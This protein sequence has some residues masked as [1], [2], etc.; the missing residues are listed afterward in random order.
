[1]K[2]MLLAAGRGERLRPLTDT[3]PKPL[4]SVGGETLIE[5][6]VNRLRQAGIT[7]LVINI[8][9]LREQIIEKLGDGSR[10]GVRIHWSDEQDNS[11]GTG[12][13]IYHARRWLGDDPWL[14]IN[15]DVY[16]D[17]TPSQPEL[18]N[19][20]LAH[21]IM[22]DN[23]HHC[24]DGNFTLH[25]GKIGLNN[26]PKLTFS[27]IGYYRRKLFSSYPEKVFALTDVLI[28]AIEQ[29]LVT[30]S[31]YQGLWEDVGTMESLKR[32]RATLS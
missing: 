5:R 24:P 31:H 13:G 14:V 16:T 9:H 18:S 19:G 15:T 21:L 4:I 11:L 32:L 2:A 23:P 1:M 22:V 3:T 7:E 28:P 25:N 12:G 20:T 17:W 30:G 10:Y 29:G 8:S 27:G 26:S 6:H